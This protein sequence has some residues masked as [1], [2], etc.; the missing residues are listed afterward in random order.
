MKFCLIRLC[1]GS[2]RS[3]S[4][5]MD[6]PADGVLVVPR[7]VRE[8]G[9]PEAREVKLPATEKANVQQEGERKTSGTE[10]DDQTLGLKDL[11]KDDLLQLLGV[12]EREIQA[13][14]DV[15]RLLRAR[16]GCPE[17]LESQYGSAC[18]TRPL[19]ALQRDGLLLNGHI[20]RD[21][22][23]E[24]PMAEL[25]RLQYKHRETYRRMLE[26]LLLAEKCHRRTVHELDTEKR[27]HADYMNKSDDFTNLLEQER[28]RLKLLLKQE[29]AFQIR[30]EKEHSKRLEKVRREL[31]KLKTFAL[32]LVDEQQ[33]HLEQI[34]QQSQK[35]QELH[36][37]LQEKEQELS[38]AESKS[39][40][41]GQKLLR[42]EVELE[43][44]SS[45]FARE[46]DEMTAKLASQ[47][48]Q[49]RQLCQ[50]QG[51]LS[52]TVEELERKNVVL[53]KSAEELQELRD[54]ISKGE[55]GNS[56]LM[57][58][59]EN[60]RKRVLEM[61]GKDEEIAKA[62]NQC[63]ELKKK[64]QAEGIHSKELKL[65]VDNLQKRM[66]E[67]ERLE[68]AFSVGRTECA[69]LQGALEKERT[70]TKELAD[71]LVMVKIRMKELESSELK[72]E[73]A[74]LVLKEELTK[75]K[76]VAV[77]MVNEHKNMAERVRSE[78]KR[79]EE[80]DGLF[81]AE[82]EKVTEVTERL[83]DESKRFLKLK[84]EM[85]RKI[86]TLIKEKEEL[87]VRHPA[88]EEECRDLSSK[89]RTRKHKNEKSRNGGNESTIKAFCKDEDAH[90]N[91]SRMDEKEAT[92]LSVEVERLRSRLKQLEVVEGDLIKTE[93]EYDV[94]KKRFKCEQ[95]KA[96]SLS[97]QVEEMR[98][99]IASSK[100]VE[101]GEAAGQETEL[102]RRCRSEEARNR[103]LQADVQ[104]LKEKIH[105]LMNKEDQLSQ[106]QVDYSVL[107]RKFLEE[108][109][110][111]KNMSN[112]VLDLTKELEMTKRY[113]RALRPSSNG[114]RM[115]DVPVT[116]TG[117]Q[118]DAAQSPA[119]DDDD[120]D[121]PAVFIKKSVQEENHIMRS[122]RQRSVKKSTERPTV[123][124]L[125][126]PA[127]ASDLSL[128]K[129]WI[130]WIRKKDC[131]VQS[132]PERAN[133]DGE[134]VHS[135]IKLTQKQGQPLHVRVTPDRQSS[136]TTLQVSGSPA[137]NIF[138]GSVATP[139]QSA[140]KPQIP[141]IPSTVVS[142]NE[143]SR[144]PRSLE[145]AKSPLTIT[146]VS[147]TKSPESIKTAP[148][149]RCTSP[150]SFMSVNTSILSDTSSSPEPQE[151]I[152]DRAVFKVTPEKRVVPMPIKKC[153]IVATED[154]KIHNHLGPPFKK[155][156]E[157]SSSAVALRHVAGE[158][159]ELSVG[160]VLRSPRQGTACKAAASKVMSS[161]TITQVNTS[162]ARPTLSVQPVAETQTFRCG[163]TRIPMSRGMKAGK[164]V[165]GAPGISAGV[166]TESKAEGQS[167]CTEVKKPSVSG[168]D[169]GVKRS[170]H[171]QGEGCGSQSEQREGNIQQDRKTPL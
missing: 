118:T 10:K 152:T 146:T 153:N 154:N 131:H 78:E 92:E 138:N 42:L 7:A 41:D 102:R 12:M 26:Q 48:A 13:R 86:T 56:N 136:K 17:V 151:M 77:M 28:E 52:Q 145:R 51:T 79:R 55:C 74:E 54:K 107:Q 139:S 80:L 76:S 99:Q 29:K 96:N 85:E 120:D 171:T 23:Y 150:V 9:E 61:E 147:R 168:K 163:L 144:E 134:T 27:K 65:E 167:M 95:E 44:R 2:M 62:D 75:L 33:F 115:V 94:L 14:E 43:V 112:E 69:H 135:E 170:T 63:R 32:V 31:I 164:A 11:S 20:R 67:L 160:T 157:N 140:Q 39:K 37:Q 60:L 73:K 97:R 57:A 122:L 18:P 137:D 16:L 45:K 158:S 142:P 110:K 141:I 59:L 4:N 66:T 126:P 149:A 130:P 3:K 155:A 6:N 81:K 106:L 129:S 124:E 15:I 161:I 24:K 105:E 1:R 125:Y 121:T 5:G 103:D 128:K 123:R 133:S 91:S 46:H 117:V 109:D 90:S 71:E 40:E 159:R 83:I 166:R 47:E 88:E 50:K 25:D 98:S 111:K 108:E 156:C 162:P 104:A 34:D 84:S 119:A 36:Q 49:H 70:V 143:R 165:V 87:K 101:R 89:S 53:L 21:N 30:K 8:L 127:A 148:P 38:G 113:S 35:I 22:V 82:Q 100:E 58:E 64:L 169:S 116:S 68:A 19:Q 72:L 93:D 114:R 132:A